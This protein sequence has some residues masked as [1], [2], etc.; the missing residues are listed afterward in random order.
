MI[1]R[2]PRSTLFPYTT[3]F[4]SDLVVDSEKLPGRDFRRVVAVISFHGQVNAC[5]QLAIDLRQL[6][7]REAEE[8]GDRLKLRDDHKTVLVVRVDNVTGIHEAQADAA[9]DRRSDVAI[10]ELQFGVIDLRSEERRVGKECRSRWSP[11][12]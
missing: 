3:L 12:H 6:V 8:R 4:R 10:G 7:L 5:T 2:P 9:A 1:R 11:Y